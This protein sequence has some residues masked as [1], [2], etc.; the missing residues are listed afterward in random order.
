MLPTSDATAPAAPRPKP[1]AH[2]LI[3]ALSSCRRHAVRMVCGPMLIGGLA[4]V[5]KISIKGAPTCGPIQSGGIHSGTS[6]L[7][8]GCQPSWPGM[9]TDSRSGDA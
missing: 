4:S 6:T 3:H 9:K 5:L 2:L 8:S 1:C 7:S